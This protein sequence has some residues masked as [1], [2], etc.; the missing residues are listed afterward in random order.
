TSETSRR[1]VFSRVEETGTIQPTVD[2]PV[3]PDVS[4]EVVSISVKEGQKVKKGDLL[5]TI[6]PD[7]YKAQLEQAR[8]S[9]SRFK[10]AYLQAKAAFTQSSA[11][12][13]QDSVTLARTKKLYKD[14]VISLVDLEN[15]QLSYKVSRSQVQSA[16]FN[17]DAA[18]YQIKNA[19]ATAAQA[20]QSLDRTNIY[21]SIDGTV[22]LLNVELGQRVVGTGMMSGT[23]ILK[24]ADLSSMEVLVQIN[25]NSI[26]NVDLGQ[27]AN[28]EVDAYPGQK[29]AGFVTEIAYS[30]NTS[31]VAT[32]DQVT[33]FD[34]KVAIDPSSYNELVK[35]G[36]N[37]PFRPGMTAI[38]EILT[39]T[40]NDVLT[41]PIESVG[42]KDGKEMV[43]I[44]EDGRVK[45]SN[46]GI[47]ITDNNYIEVTEGL[48]DGAEIITGPSTLLRSGKMTVGMEVSKKAEQVEEKKGK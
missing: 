14:G 34:V 36:K 29:F 15:A 32:T 7:D 42:V 4:G 45:Q 27:K 24:V 28:I 30:A 1:T 2:V 19:E 22:T 41:V 5:V 16:K 35:Q 48:S 12:L 46:I 37:N 17:T 23:E 33:N 18:F 47:G 31:Q 44:L 20:R 43:F 11:T 38:V 6:R 39:D 10:A 26:V 21:A 40:A 9:V 3:A 13:L 8:A 25:E